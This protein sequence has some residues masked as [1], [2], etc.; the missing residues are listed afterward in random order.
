MKRL[1]VYCTARLPKIIYRAARKSSNEAGLGSGMLKYDSAIACF[2]LH[3]ALTFPS[4]IS[5]AAAVFAEYSVTKYQV[6]SA[7][8]LPISDD[9]AWDL[10]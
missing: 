2:P 4:R 9:I 3:S 1:N 10:V 5:L 6:T 8:I 7:P